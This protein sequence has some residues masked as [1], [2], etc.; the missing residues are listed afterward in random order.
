MSNYRIHLLHVIDLGK[1]CFRCISSGCKKDKRRV[2]V[3]ARVDQGVPDWPNHSDGAAQTSIA[4]LEGMQPTR[5]SY[6]RQKC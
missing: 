1:M 3:P 5:E 4:A 2:T 6:F